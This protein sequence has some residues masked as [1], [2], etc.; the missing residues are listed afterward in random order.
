MT[1]YP[2]PITTGTSVNGVRSLGGTG[3]VPGVVSRP[4]PA[5]LH[6][7]TMADF[8]PWREGT[9]PALRG[10]EGQEAARGELV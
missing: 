4:R 8:R 6:R 5:L 9:D 7:R 3:V 10:R 2:F 1:D